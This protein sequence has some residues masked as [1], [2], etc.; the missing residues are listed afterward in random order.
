MFDILILLQMYTS[1]DYSF[2]SFSLKHCIQ[3]FLLENSQLIL[4][5]EN[6][7]CMQA[8]NDIFC[9]CCYDLPLILS[10]NIHHF[11]I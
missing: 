2:E 4:M 3:L 1:Y 7:N 6:D 11:G 9:V 10:C 5:E 8:I